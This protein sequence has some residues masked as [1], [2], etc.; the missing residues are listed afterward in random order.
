VKP[1]ETRAIVYTETNNGAITDSFTG[2]MADRGAQVSVLPRTMMV[3]SFFV[4]YAFV[5]ADV[6]E[7]PVAP[8]LFGP[9]W[10][11]P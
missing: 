10:W 2:T 5:A 4:G 6:A 11:T 3:G 8:E 9:D 1:A 7:T